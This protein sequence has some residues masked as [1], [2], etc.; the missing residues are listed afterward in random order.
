MGDFYVEPEKD[1]GELHPPLSVTASDE[2][3]RSLERLADV[4]W[5]R[6]QAGQ[7][8]TSAFEQSELH[9]LALAQQ[10]LER[11]KADKARVMQRAYEEWLV[12]PAS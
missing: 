1:T 2:E 6:I 3:V 11:S 9:E 8:D 7:W 5:A 4:V 10:E 12:Q